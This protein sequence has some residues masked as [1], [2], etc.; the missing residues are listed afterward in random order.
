[1]AV[2]AGAAS[3]AGLGER[4]APEHP[5]QRR[6][7]CRV[8]P[9]RWDPRPGSWL[10]PAP[11]AATPARARSERARGRGGP[12]TQT[13]TGRGPCAQSP[14]P[15]RWR[16]EETRRVGRRQSPRH[17]LFHLPPLLPE[18]LRRG[19]GTGTGTGGVRGPTGAA[20]HSGAAARGVTG[21][22]MPAHPR[23]SELGRRAAAATA[24]PSGL[25]ARRF[26]T[27]HPHER[28]S[29][30]PARQPPSAAL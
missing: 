20:G 9:D 25:P 21:T 26:S 28:A 29:R 15:S 8:A 17:R 4:R 24:S 18:R 12:G 11:C 5:A 3:L 19:L 23:R 30:R 2:A 13:L 14:C 27:R 16:G 7:L 22:T 1:M 6:H 10:L